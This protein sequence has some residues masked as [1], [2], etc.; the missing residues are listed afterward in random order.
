MKRRT[1]FRCLT[2]IIILMVFVIQNSPYA[3]AHS[4]SQDGILSKTYISQY[5]GYYIGGEDVGWSIDEE[6]H[7]NG[8]TIAFAFMDWDRNLTDAHRS[9][10]I[11]GASL[12]GGTI[13]I[14]NVTD[15]SDT[16]LICTFNS[17]NTGI[18]AK[19]NR[20]VVDSSG[21]LIN[22]EIQL[23]RSYTQSARVL[24]HEFGHVIGLNDLYES[25]NSGKLMY[26]Y[27]TGSATGP[28]SSDRWGAKVI[29]G[30]HVQHTWGYKYWETN[31]MGNAHIKYCTSCSGLTGDVRQCTY[32]SDNHC[33]VCGANKFVPVE[34]S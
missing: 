2:Y 15:G 10:T 24:A 8:T 13:T 7:T 16:G 11:A 23:N 14:T 32:G 21:H 6:H 9:Y 3:L 34:G 26:G 27:A 33:T 30:V 25:R 12:W 31:S 18:I 4:S 29:T 5:Q 28:T 17:P 1:M 22:W 20:S 19:T